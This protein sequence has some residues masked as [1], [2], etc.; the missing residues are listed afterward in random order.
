MTNESAQVEETVPIIQ[1]KIKTKK[2]IEKEQEKGE[3][4]DA[5]FDG[6][7]TEKDD[8]ND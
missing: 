7:E 4:G 2:G 5:G 8:A 3:V 1:P 6:L